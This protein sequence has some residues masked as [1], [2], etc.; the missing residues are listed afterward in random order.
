[1]NEALLFGWTVYLEI[2]REMAIAWKGSRWEN[3]GDGRER[4]R[5]VNQDGKVENKNGEKKPK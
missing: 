2:A 1:M 3:M 5:Q 4:R